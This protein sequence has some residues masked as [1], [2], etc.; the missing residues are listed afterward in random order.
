[1]PATPHSPAPGGGAVRLMEL[2]A[3]PDLH[4][5]QVGGPAEERLISMVQ[6]SELDDPARYLLGGELLLTAGVHFPETATGIDVYVRRLVAA[7]IAALGFGLAPV[8]TEVPPEL[9]AACDRYGLPLL[10]VPPQTPFV[11]VG[12]AFHLAM[13]EARNRDLRRVSEA[14]SALASA[15]ARPDAVEAVLRQLAA[16]IGAWTVLM[17]VH[18]TE[19]F[20]AGAR[21]DVPVPDRLRAL[22]TSTVAKQRRPDAPSRLPSAATEHHAGRQL[23]VHTLPGTEQNAGALVLGLAAG[24][25]LS[26]VDHQV[27]GVGTVLLSLLTGPRR[28]LGDDTGGSA[29]LVGLLLGADP[30]QVASLLHPDGTGPSSHWRVVHGRRKPSGTARTPAPSTADPVHLA[31]L[32]TALGTSYLAVDG[33]IL[34]ALVPVTDGGAADRSA[35][36][37]RLGWTLGFSSP[38]PATDLTVAD[39][40]AARALDQ[41]LARGTTSV[42][43]RVQD[44]GLHGLVDPAEASALARARFAPL[45]TAGTPGAAALLETLRTWLS[46]HGGWDRTAAALGVHRN[47]VRQRIARIAELLD[48]DLDDADVRMD[49]W[50]ALRW[51][52]DEQQPA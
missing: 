41:A 44:A 38:V 4:L 13:A 45:A 22:A 19:L 8:H 32:G 11:A 40:Q 31:T 2:I 35:A 37:A 51:L 14:Q 5:R 36:L 16:R 21:P 28:A 10:R 49:L 20:A 46:L 17:D 7:R 23:I 48:T 12:R 33:G 25:Q 42:H 50:F 34:R 43:H 52:P 29:A 6:S 1:M 39:A 24:S 27:A 3:H 9:F 47:T 15:A 18:G 30:A 26:P